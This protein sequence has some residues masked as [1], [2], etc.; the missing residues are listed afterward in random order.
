MGLVVSI[1]SPETSSSPLLLEEDEPVFSD[2][3]VAAWRE[4][5]MQM[6]ASILLNLFP[7]N[8]LAKSEASFTM[9][10]L[11][12]MLIYLLQALKLQ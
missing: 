2:L 9:M 4:C 3:M 10:M 6:S 7:L 8:Y 1:C 11:E 12:F 5:T